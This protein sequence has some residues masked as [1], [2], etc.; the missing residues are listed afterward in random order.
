MYVL[1]H[2]NHIYTMNHD[3]K[4]LAK[5]LHKEYKIN[6][7]PS[8]D[9]MFQFDDNDEDIQFKMIDSIDDIFHGIEADITR[10][11]ASPFFYYRSRQSG[12]WNDPNSWEMSNTP[13]FSSGITTPV[14]TCPN[15]SNSIQIKVRNNHVITVTSNVSASSTTLEAGGNIIV[16]SGI[17][18]TIF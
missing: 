7:K 11:T 5:Q 15:S 9:Y 16:N 18:F 17:E 3:I 8:S 4:V 1:Q 10:K 13:D 2:D 12:R 14:I 6:V